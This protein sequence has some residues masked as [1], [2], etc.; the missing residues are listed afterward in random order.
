MVPHLSVID[1]HGINGGKTMAEPNQGEAGKERRELR[2]DDLIGRLVPDPANTDLVRLAG[3]FLGNSEREAYWRLYLTTSL[4]HYLEFRKEDTVDAERFPSGA[5]VVWLKPEARVQER[6][7]RSIP[8]AFLQGN[9]S[10]MYLPRTTDVSGLR[11]LL[12]LAGPGC[13]PKTPHT[14]QNTCQVGCDTPFPSP[15]CDT[16]IG[17]TC[18][19]C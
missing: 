16:K 15:F 8:A 14:Q 2:Q 17:Y 4:N 9:I 1:E 13:D 18:E 10:S 6:I 11:Q 3:L 19:G 7:T 12:R 5:I